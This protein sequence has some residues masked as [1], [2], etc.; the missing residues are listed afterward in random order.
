MGRASPKLLELHFSGLFPRCSLVL[1]ELGAT[2]CV[3]PKDYDKPIQQAQGFKASGNE[4]VPEAPRDVK[5]LVGMTKWGIDYT[6]DCLLAAVL[7]MWES[8]QA[9]DL[10]RDLSAT[11]RPEGTGN[12]EVMRAALE[13]LGHERLCGSIAGSSC[14]FVL[15]WW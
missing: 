12:T 3:N 1:E 10:S 13:P 8:I 9:L 15:V 5:V 11:C 14:V 7:R 2:D 6:F 4:G